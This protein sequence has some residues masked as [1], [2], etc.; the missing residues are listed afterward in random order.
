MFFVVLFKAQIYTWLKWA[1]FTS[2]GELI[3]KFVRLTEVS[4]RYKANL[5]IATY[6][7][8][9]MFTTRQL[10]LSKLLF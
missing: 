9:C 10:T 3:V 8:I 2:G 4:S 7:N 6:V 5:E 1:S